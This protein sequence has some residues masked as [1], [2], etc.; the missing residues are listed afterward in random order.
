MSEQ[1]KIIHASLLTALQNELTVEGQES[2]LS[3]YLMEV[4]KYPHINILCREQ[5]KTILRHK[6][7]SSSQSKTIFTDTFLQPTKPS[8]LNLNCSV[9]SEEERRKP[10]LINKQVAYKKAISNNSRCSNE[11]SINNNNQQEDYKVNVNVKETNAQ[12]GFVRANRLLPKK[13]QREESPKEEYKE[14]G[15]RRKFV[16][17]FANP[18]KRA[19]YST[20]PKN[21]PPKQQE[22]KSVKKEN[23]KLIE[24]IESEILDSSPCVSWNEIAGLDYAKKTI[25]EILILP[26]TMPELREIIDLPHGILLFGPPGTGKTMIAKAVA[27]ECKSTFFNISSSILTSKW[28]GE[29]EKL[30]RT[31]FEVAKQRQPSIIFIDE[32]DSLL[33]ARSEN[34]FE[35]SRRIK[36]EFLVRMDGVAGSQSD[37]VIIIGATNR[38]QELDEAVKRRLGKRLYIPLPNKAGRIDF[39]T[40]ALERSKLGSILTKEEVEELAVVTKGYSGADLKHLI[41]EAAMY[42][43]RTILG[44]R[45]VK[46]SEIRKI[47]Y[48]DFKLALGA[49]KATVSKDELGKYLEWN[50][51]YGCC[52]F[53]E[54]DLDN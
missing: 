43:V 36:T 7:P 18:D 15:T 28:M 44:K 9:W 45:N 24:Q 42:P 23:D 6:P 52:P 22:E 1:D 20:V 31:L 12:N 3:F 47:S 14:E 5:I 2:L 13:K 33:C 46:V 38:P 37:Q 21:P 8:W 34:D 39:L 40:K 51:S 53:T 25:E 19:E 26:I 30:V 48:E 35:S 10:P 32:I 16:P 41:S 49:V 27:T 54:A 17:P 4:K 11:V 50:A 29:G